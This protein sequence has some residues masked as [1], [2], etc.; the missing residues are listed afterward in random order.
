MRVSDLRADLAQ[1]PSQNPIG[2]SSADRLGP[3]TRV[4]NLVRDLTPKSAHGT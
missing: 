2:L 4:S 3:Y 1:G